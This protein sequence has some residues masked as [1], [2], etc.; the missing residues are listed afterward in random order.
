MTQSG[1]RLDHRAGDLTRSLLGR[2][3]ADLRPLVL[4]RAVFNSGF[5]LL[6]C[7]VAYLGNG[8]VIAH[9]FYVDDYTFA[10]GCANNPPI[11][12]KRIG[13]IDQKSVA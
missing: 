3:K 6:P 13:K 12:Q 4:C 11:S 1:R 8:L 10:V 7:L 5:R 9:G 2:A